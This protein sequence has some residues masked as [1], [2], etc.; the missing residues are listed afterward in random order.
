ML[1]NDLLFIAVPICMASGYLWVAVQ[2]GKGR[3]ADL[4]RVLR[5]VLASEAGATVVAEL[6]TRPA[7]RE[8]FVDPP[9]P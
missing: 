9:I 7:S 1:R 5:V 8:S 4:I 2:V 3:D 6:L